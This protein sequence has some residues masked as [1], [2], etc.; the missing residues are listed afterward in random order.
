ILLL[1]LTSALAAC[2]RSGVIPRYG[3]IGIVQGNGVTRAA[4]FDLGEAPLGAT[5]V[6]EVEVRNTGSGEL[7]LLAPIEQTLAPDESVR[8]SFE[9][10]VPE[11][12]A[13]RVTQIFEL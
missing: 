3:R 5:F 6:R 12:P 10:T 7:E 4:T 2:G 1:A 11:L 8:V 9:V 13:E